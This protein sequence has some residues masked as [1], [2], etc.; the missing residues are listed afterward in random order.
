MLSDTLAN[1]KLTCTLLLDQ[2]G[3]QANSYLKV[4]QSHT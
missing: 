2:K 1:L 3:G 4:N